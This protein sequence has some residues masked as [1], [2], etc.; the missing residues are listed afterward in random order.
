[1]RHSRLSACVLALCVAAIPG[2][3]RADSF[4]VQLGGMRF[5]PGDPS[6]FSLAGDDFSIF[7]EG[8]RIATTSGDFTCVTGCAPGTAIDLGTVFGSALRDFHL[9]EGDATIR[10]TTFGGV[11]EPVLFRGTLTFET[12]SVVVPTN[13]GDLIQLTAPFTFRGRIAGFL[14]P[15]MSD[16]LF[17]HDFAGRGRATMDL[18]RFDASGSYHFLE[19][20][21]RFEPAVVPE[22]GTLVLLGGG[23]AGLWARTRRRKSP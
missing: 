9:G 17:E 23:L 5:D 1:M 21:Y 11:D 15:P 6:L 19:M 14:E 10:G 16:L 2:T 22:P 4:V 13:A 20:S 3:V 7:G 8:A 18:G 12:S